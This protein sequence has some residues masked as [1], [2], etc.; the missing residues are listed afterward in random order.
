MVTACVPIPQ[1]DVQFMRS[2]GTGGSTSEAV[3]TA[4][5]L[6][7]VPAQNWHEGILTAA[8]RESSYNWNA[9]NAWDRNASGR[10]AP[11]GYPVN[12]SRGV[13]QVIPRTF[14]R[15]HHPGTSN[16]IYDGV[17]NICAAMHYVMDRYRVC[18]DG[19]DLVEK[20]QQFDHRRP[21]RGY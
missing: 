11:D 1:S 3:E 13:L 2:K 6:L 9:V 17:A 16:N 21:P 5:Q 18:P 19:S 14:A 8:A 7:G 12:C 10:R 4:C 15:Y 20:V